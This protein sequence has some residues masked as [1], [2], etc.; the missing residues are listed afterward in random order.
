MDVLRKRHTGT[1]WKHWFPELPDMPFSFALTRFLTNKIVEV[2]PSCHRLRQMAKPVGTSIRER[3][4]T[5]GAF[6]NVL[7]VKAKV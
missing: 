4:T 6:G 7:N 1:P 2:V 5:L 3:N